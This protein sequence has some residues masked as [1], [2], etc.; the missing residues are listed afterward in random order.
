MAQPPR[1]TSPL[2]PFLVQFLA[3]VAKTEKGFQPGP[4]SATVASRMDLPRAFIDALFTSARTRALIKPIYGR[5][6]KIRWTVSPEGE[7]FLRDHSS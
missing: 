5:G 1:S 4:E 2:D 6:S 3:H 7:A